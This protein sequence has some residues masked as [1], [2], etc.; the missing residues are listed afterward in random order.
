MIKQSKTVAES[1]AKN[2]ARKSCPLRAIPA[3]VRIQAQS[4]DNLLDRIC[5]GLVWN[6]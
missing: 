4:L 6:G 2:A 5:S 3:A 1:K